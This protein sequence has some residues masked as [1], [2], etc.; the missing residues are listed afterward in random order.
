MQCWQKNVF[1]G[2][3]Q[4]GAM[5]KARSSLL[6]LLAIGERKSYGSL[7]AEPKKQKEKTPSPEDSN[8]PPSPGPPRCL[9]PPLHGLL[10]STQTFLSTALS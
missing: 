7:R 5:V 8:W 1:A 6:S 4:H 2:K 3:E 9:N 10:L